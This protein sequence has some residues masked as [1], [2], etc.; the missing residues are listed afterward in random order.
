VLVPV[1]GFA[2]AVAVVFTIVSGADILWRYRHLIGLGEGERGGASPVDPSASELGVLLG[3]EGLTVAVA[4]SCTAGLLG[5][6]I[7]DRPGSSTYFLGG[8]IAYSD[9]VK[10]DE[11]SVPAAL[12]SRH[13]AVSREVALAMASGA[14]Q[15]F[16]TS[17]A[18]SIT[19]IAG[20]AAE[21]TAKPIGLTYIAV[22]SE[23]GSR[24]EEYTFTGDRWSNRRQAAAQALRLLI[25]EVRASAGRQD[26]R[27]PA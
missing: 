12:L 18:A 14:R 4:E 5:A 19:C 25:D 16:G 15:R 22:D 20:P 8:V 26:S 9:E 2:V 11:L 24:C 7:T 21:G 1:A 17:L 23:W 10:R 13:G 27:R 3:R 6:L